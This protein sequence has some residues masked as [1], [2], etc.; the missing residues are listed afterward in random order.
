MKPENLASLPT[1]TYKSSPSRASL[2]VLEAQGMLVHHL[3]GH[4]CQGRRAG[5]QCALRSKR[6]VKIPPR[7]GSD[8]TAMLK[9]DS[10]CLTLHLQLD[11]CLGS[12]PYIIFHLQ[13]KSGLR[14][15]VDID[16]IFF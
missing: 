12:G 5:R 3:W 7:P 8:F 11:S 10:L 2:S 6:S 13:W 9:S 15:Q 14:L 16:V 4:Q 1:M